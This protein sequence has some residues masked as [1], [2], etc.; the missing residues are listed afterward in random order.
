MFISIA[1]FAWSL[2][3]LSI[4]HAP[5]C[6][7]RGTP[8]ADGAT[9]ISQCP[10]NPGET[11]IYKFVASEA[12][13]F[14][15]HGHFGLQRSAGFYGSLIV[16]PA[17]GAPPEPFHYDEE[18]S[19]IV[20][21]W[22]HRNIYDQSAGLFSDPFR[23]VG[24]PQSL[25]IE[26]RGAYNCSLVPQGAVAGSGDAVSCNATRPQCAPYVLSVV[27]GKTYR[28]RIASAASLSSLNFVLE[29]G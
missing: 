28:L 10:I 16:L 24:E 12:G 5:V 6:L 25:L 8:W 22:W 2:R 21:D 13:T 9:Y 1:N 23:F 20:N 15:Y 7:Q 14:L 4:A 17:H 29:V 11:F 26:G 18:L 19:I 27:P 3:D